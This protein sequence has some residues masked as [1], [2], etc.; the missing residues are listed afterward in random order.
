MSF[1]GPISSFQR[2]PKVPFQSVLN[3]TKKT[4]SLREVKKIP[5]LRAGGRNKSNAQKKI[6]FFFWDSFP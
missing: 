5:E 2:Y 1:G 6:C 4:F 3:N